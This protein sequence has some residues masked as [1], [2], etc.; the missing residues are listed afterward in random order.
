MTIKLAISDAINPIEKQKD[1]LEK[2]LA[3][4]KHNSET[5]ELEK[6]NLKTSLES[7]YLQELQ[8]KD[9]IIKYKD[10]EIERVKDMK[11]KFSTKM[12]GES[13][14]Q[15]CEIEFNKLRA[16]AFPTAEFN[17]D[18]DISSGTKGDFIYRENDSSGN[19]IISIMFE[20]K[21]EN[22]DTISKKKNE[23]FFAKLDKDRKN[24][25]CEYAILVFTVR[26]R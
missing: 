18:N 2:K 13:L 26:I 20:M 17:K 7:K 14:E 15:H 25:G 4:F 8:S 5:K 23:D 21:N 9:T 19:E 6:E 3:Y 22:E 12:L 11:Q 10:E 1:E 24:K 16:T